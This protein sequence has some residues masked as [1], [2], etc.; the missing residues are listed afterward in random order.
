M[1]EPTPRN[2]RKGIDLAARWLV[3]TSLA[4]DIQSA[5][6][7]RR[8]D[9]RE[10]IV[11][12]GSENTREALKRTSYA[13]LHDYFITTRTYNAKL[14]DGAILQ[15]EYEFENGSILRH[16]LAYLPSAT[17]EPFQSHA[18]FPSSE[19][20]EA[21]VAASAVVPVP[22]RFDFDIAAHVDRLH[23]ASHLTLGQ[24]VG[25]RI[26]VTA[27]V[28]P[29]LFIEFIIRNFYSSVFLKF[30]DAFPSSA[31]RFSRTVIDSE[32]GLTHLRLPK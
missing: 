1:T 31:L 22:V 12:P 3:E 6:G 2:I 17:N 29:Q 32:E 28:T 5:I 18:D 8:R 23:P 9:G 20:H 21:D 16:R 24:H 11:F 4:D 14:L 25:C 19:A 26:P 13:E 27:P 7:E 10:I 30:Q 15:L